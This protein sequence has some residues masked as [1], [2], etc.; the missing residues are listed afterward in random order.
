M[1]FDT[2]LNICEQ[3][4]YKSWHI[5]EF[6]I[7][8]LLLPACISFSLLFLSPF[9]PLLITT[10]TFKW[11]LPWLFQLKLTTC[12]L[13]AVE[14]TYWIRI[15]LCY[16]FYLERSLLILLYINFHLPGNN[17]NWSGIISLADLAHFRLSYLSEPITASKSIL[18]T[19]IK[20]LTDIYHW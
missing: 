9:L 5:W 7:S 3:S 12:F 4:Q 18:R 2:T 15:K 8:Q 13:T 11:S 17:V 1:F 20:H 10:T 14:H 19:N 6:S 16:E